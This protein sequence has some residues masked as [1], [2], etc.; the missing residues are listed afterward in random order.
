MTDKKIN[1]EEYKP[2]PH[3]FKAVFKQHGITTG[4]IA[5]YLD[6]SYTYISNI[7]NGHYRM[8]KKMYTMLLEVVRQL[9]SEE[10][11]V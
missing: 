1:L 5:N 10:V 7:L 9:K 11:E 3:P 8:P 2:K 4:T 6:K